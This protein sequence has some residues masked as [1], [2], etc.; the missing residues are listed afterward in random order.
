[1]QR[2]SANRVRL[3]MRWMLTVALLCGLAE[4]KHK[5]NASYKRKR[6]EE[7][8][9]H[10]KKALELAPFNTAVL[11]NIAQCY[12]R[13][14][15]LD[16]C[17]EFCSRTLFIDPNHVKA[18]SRRSTVLHRQ[19]KLKEA[20]EDMRK[21][22]TLEPDNPDVVEQHS[23]IVGDYED[24]MTSS[25][26]D[27]VVRGDSK[28][29]GTLSSS[30]V[31]E[32]R[33]VREVLQKMNQQDGEV[34]SRQPQI[35]N[36]NSSEGVDTSN[37]DSPE[38]DAGVSWQWAAYDLMLPF[39][40]H[41][42]HV[43]DHLRTSGELFKLCNRLC[44]IFDAAG[45]SSGEDDSISTKAKTDNDGF[46]LIVSGMLNCVAAAL[47]NTPRNQVVLFRQKEFREKVLAVLGD[48]HMTSRR[49]APAPA[50]SG[51]V[52]NSMEVQ[53]S[54]FRVIEEAIDSKA[55]KQAV[56]A[57]QP[58]LNALLRSL[59]SAPGGKIS[60]RKESLAAQSRAL[61]SSSI[62]FTISS[63]ASGINALL[64]SPDAAGDRI[65]AIARSIEAHR[66]S[67]SPTLSNLLGFL[68]NMTTSEAFRA[69]VEAGERGN[70]RALLVK[71][72]LSIALS[73]Y[74][75]AT[76]ST[77]YTLSERALASLLNLSFQETSRI[78][79]LDL[80]ELDAVRTLHRVFAHMQ[81]EAFVPS[82]CVLSR[83][84]SLLCR[85]HFVSGIA[86]KSD[87]MVHCHEQM[88]ED[89]ILT[90]LFRIC[91]QAFASHKHRVAVTD[92]IWQA[93]AQVWCHFG[94]CAHLPNV[95][96]LLRDLKALP[97][98]FKAIDL[99]N[100]HNIYRSPFKASG[101]SME[102]LVGN[103]VKVL[104]AL[105]GDHQPED[106]G[107]FA[108][109][110][111]LKVLVAALQRL[112]DGLARKNVAILLAKLCQSDA[113]IKSTVKSLRGIEMMMSISQSLQKSGGGRETR[114][115][116]ANPAA[117]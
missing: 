44:S 17:V 94:W 54:L 74:T 117:Y 10:Y 114:S 101:N 107:S 59:Q 7:A 25:Q 58:C 97:L 92:E 110:K 88:S 99:A 26:L 67:A 113:E 100:D 40:E 36:Q 77:D 82:V 64:S 50:M 109:K 103:I 85:L 72:L 96:A 3:W 61:S 75:A 22:L 95:R 90:D 1:M 111:S 49:D 37:D 31:E 4:L 63:D 115:L 39:I 91:E 76:A 98:L 89:G 38:M 73:C 35:G 27:S 29:A 78:R 47:A 2:V 69:A 46:E 20:A 24:S 70:E 56:V 48:T 32:L 105:E 34:A 16:D 102:R 15:Q 79:T 43:R 30:Q 80:V 13:M 112:P 84:V 51:S 62:C 71:S 23:I 42:Q 104:I 65:V 87:K 57:S 33:F 14:E 83:A 116:K 5:G 19:K 45:E 60:G 53:A 93:C 41:N 18:L 81:P 6:Y 86:V 8:I 108:E 21:A 9:E 106:C 52:L 12:L 11:A 66:S 55:W 68:T 28:A